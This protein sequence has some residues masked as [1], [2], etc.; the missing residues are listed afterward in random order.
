MFYTYIY[1]TFIIL[2][3]YIVD[4]WQL[5]QLV[6]LFILKHWKNIRNSKFH[7]EDI[8]VICTTHAPQMRNSDSVAPYDGYILYHLVPKWPTDDAINSKLDNK[9]GLSFCC[10]GR[11][12]WRP[13]NSKVLKRDYYIYSE[14]VQR[15][16]PSLHSVIQL[17]CVVCQHRIVW[18]SPLGF[19]PGPGQG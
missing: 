15:C 17:L 2:T 19:S 10:P 7:H 9:F 1:R 12:V 4:G 6:G 11:L 5:V 8:V 16:M 18:V 13:R 14:I 3:L